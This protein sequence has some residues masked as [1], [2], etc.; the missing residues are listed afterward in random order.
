MTSQ[1]AMRN[2]GFITFFLSGICAIS[3]GIIVSILQEKYGFSF[4]ATG[5]LLSLM[6]IGNMAAAFLSGVLPEK[7]GVRA[8]VLILSAGYL[9]GYLLTAWIG[10]PGVLMAGFIMIGLAKGCALNR[11][12]VL[13]G[14]NSENRSRGLQIMHACYACGALLCPFLISGLSS[15]SSTLP[16]VGVAGCGLLL[17][18]I[19]AAAR[20]PGKTGSG[21][22]ASSPAS[23]AFLRS[24]DFWLLTALIF[25]QNAAETSVTGWLVTYYRNREILSGVFSA[26]TMT[27][28]WGATLI[29]R[30]LIAFVIPIRNNY[31][32]LCFMGLGCTALYALL[33]PVHTPLAAV[34]VLFCFSFAIAGVNP[35]T[36]ASLGKEISQESLAVMLP[37]GAIGGIVMPLLIGLCADTLGLQ[38]GM[39]LNLLPCAGIAILSGIQ[40]KRHAQQDHGQGLN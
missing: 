29:A 23:R 16:M 2:T 40:W 15:V 13:V 24:S 38:T 10:W 27:V 4:G 37:T 28:M 32:A 7:I 5:T 26:Y 8:T 25:C 20:L 35:M 39:L 3:S 33:V 30:L 9:I 34:I 21:R 19:F 31:R 14:N 18:I 22:K 17:W 36:T 12:T 1:K 6:N 11:C